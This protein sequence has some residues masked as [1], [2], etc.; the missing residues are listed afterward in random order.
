MGQ[1]LL[2][3]PA[4][5]RERGGTEPRPGGSGQ[6]PRL[7]K[8]GV[9]LHLLRQRGEQPGLL[10]AARTRTFGKKIL[11]SGFEHPS[12]RRPL[13]AL[14]DAG[15]QVEFLPPA[16]DGSF[17]VAQLLDR[18]DRTTVLVACMMVNNETGARCDVERLAREVKGLNSRTVVHVDGVQA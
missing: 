3:L 9:L 4:G 15:W 1:P 2:P 16:A 7:Q 5:G 8:P 6:D 10:G 13:E 12:V 14:A 11:C 17:D 18:V